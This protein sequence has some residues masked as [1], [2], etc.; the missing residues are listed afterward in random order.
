VNDCCFTVLQDGVCRGETADE[1]AVAV[2]VRLPQGARRHGH[3]HAVQSD[4]TSDGEG[5]SRRRHVR[6]TLRALRGE[7]TAREH[8]M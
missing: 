6:R 4:Q 2:Y 5:T 7:I 8:R 3:V 1:L